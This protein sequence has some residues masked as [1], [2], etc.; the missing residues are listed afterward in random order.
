LDNSTPISTG[1]EFNAEYSR[2]TNIIPQ[3][4]KQ[5]TF[6]NNQCGEPTTPMNVQINSN[7]HDVNIIKSP[8][9]TSDLL[10]VPHSYMSWN[11]DDLSPRIAKDFEKLQEFSQYVDK[12]KPSL[13]FIQEPRLRACPEK[14]RGYVHALDAKPLTDF[15]ALFPMYE[16]YPSLATTNVAGQLML[17]RADV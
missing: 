3:C 12:C 7:N 6:N 16:C 15:M 17:L 14:G 5:V 1:A 9:T 11:I 4:V 2:L 13:L 10:K 8:Q